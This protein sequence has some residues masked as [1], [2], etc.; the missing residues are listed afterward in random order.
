MTSSAFIYAPDWL[1]ILCVTALLLVLS[2][3]FM[4]TRFPLGR[5]WRPGAVH[6]LY[7]FH[8]TAQL[9]P[10]FV[11]SLS[12]ENPAAL[13]FMLACGVA[14]L[15]IPLGAMLADFIWPEKANVHVGQEVVLYDHTLAKKSYGFGFFVGL[16]VLAITVFI[17]Y[18]LKVDVFPLL[19]ELTGVDRAIVIEN[20]KLAMAAGYLY[21]WARVFLMPLVF[22]TGLLVWRDTTRIYQKFFIILALLMAVVYTA[23]TAEKAPVARLFVLG[24]M[25]VFYSL[26]VPDLLRGGYQK[27]KKLVLGGGAA[28]LLVMVYPVFI[29]ISYDAAAER[30]L[31]YILKVGVLERIFWRPAVNTYTAF[32][33]FPHILP[34]TCFQ[35]VGKFA[36]LLGWPEIKLSQEIG[37]Y[38][39]AIPM[40]AP[41]PSIGTFYAQG[42]WMALCVGTVLAAMVFRLAE[43]FLL[44]RQGRG[45]LEIALYLLLVYGAFRFSWAKFHSIFMTEAFVPAA[46][47]FGLWVLYRNLRQRGV[48]DQPH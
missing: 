4:A 48:N 32:E 8:I 42:G 47:V 5:H 18:L 6:I 20:R 17:F 39:F 24:F 40:K 43:M 31:F 36:A 12:P 11:M 37:W 1:G 13:D 33:V 10:A 26:S 25:A 2:L 29:F 7:L 34:F 19:D 15:L 21:G 35:D 22:V 45:S 14:A 46:I 30:G 27:H 3:Y 16:T 23:Y 9:C 28:L 44:S 38:K 41:P